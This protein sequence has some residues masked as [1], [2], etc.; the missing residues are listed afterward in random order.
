MK[1][2]L[3]IMI[4]SFGIGKKLVTLLCMAEFQLN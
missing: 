3:E 2:I 1:A 4:D